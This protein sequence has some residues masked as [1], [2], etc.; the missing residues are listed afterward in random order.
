M[1][2]GWQKLSNSI[3][4][5]N[6]LFKEKIEET[7]GATEMGI[8]KQRERCEDLKGVFRHLKGPWVW[9]QRGC[10]DAP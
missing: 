1:G 4:V 7:I 10:S 3:L 5:H 9:W 6:T 8:F 2:I